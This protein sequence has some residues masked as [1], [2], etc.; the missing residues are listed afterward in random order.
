MLCVDGV[1]TASSTQDVVAW[2]VDLFSLYGYISAIYTYG[3][4][5]EYFIYECETKSSES[6]YD[7]LKI[8]NIL[9]EYVIYNGFADLR[10]V[11]MGND[12]VGYIAETIGVLSEEYDYNPYYDEHQ[13]A[14]ILEYNIIEPLILLTTLACRL[15]NRNIHDDFKKYTKYMID[16]IAAISINFKAGWFDY[17]QL[18]PTALFN[19]PDN[20]S[21]KCKDLVGA[22]FLE[23]CK[24]VKLKEDD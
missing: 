20:Y 21:F 5:E 1:K 18:L 19:Q 10:I 13:M 23:I 4:G 7:L 11:L 8:N 9:P 2:T 3:W 15:F 6:L 12:Y 16:K 22:D 24:F 17:N 14:N